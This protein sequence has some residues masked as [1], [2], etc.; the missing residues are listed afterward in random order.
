MSQTNIWPLVECLSEQAISLPSSTLTPFT[1][2]NFQIRN[3]F[4]VSS[5]S[6]I[7]YFSKHHKASGILVFMCWGPS[8]KPA[9]IWISLSSCRGLHFFT[10]TLF[11]S[12]SEAVLFQSESLGVPRVS[13]WS[14][15]L[16]LLALPSCSLCSRGIIYLVPQQSSAEPK[17]WN[18]FGVKGVGLLV[19]VK[20]LKS[21]WNWSKII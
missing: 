10:S 16:D 15:N 13:G 14:W 19:S 8:C 12:L 18:T 9:R 4:E 20:A 17:C 3:F 7:V 1:S 21:T 11:S 6:S 2:D 5:L